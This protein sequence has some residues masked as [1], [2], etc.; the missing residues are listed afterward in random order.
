MD[1]SALNLPRSTFTGADWNRSEARQT[2]CI[3]DLEHHFNSQWS[4]KA[5]AVNM[6]E[7]TSSVHQRVACP[8]S[9]TAAARSYGDFGMDFDNRKRGIDAY[10]RGKFD[11]L[12]MAQEVLVGASYV[13][14]ASD[15]GYA[16]A[17]ESGADDLQ[18]QSTTA[19]GKTSTASPRAACVP[20]ALTKYARKACMAAGTAS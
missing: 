17:W 8:S 7:N 11:G 3:L 5:S 14:L 20:S 6:Q 10:V 12:G 13:T 15:D 19:H 9:P 2:T 16:R 4:L 1:G 18:H